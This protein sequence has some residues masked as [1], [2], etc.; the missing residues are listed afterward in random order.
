MTNRIVF[1]LC[2]FLFS[3]QLFGQ[4][5]DLLVDSI[6]AIH[7]EEETNVGL[8]IG[9]INNSKANTYYYGG[10]YTQLI[11]DVD[12]TT[13]FEIGSLT[14]L[15]TALILGKL[16]EKGKINR[17]DLLSQYLP[18]S[19][20]KNSFWQSKIR[21]IDLATH[22]S[23]LPGF[24]STRSLQSFNDFDEN[25]P[26]SLFTKKFMFSVLDT[27]QHLNQYGKINYSNYGIALMALAM[28]TYTNLK[29]EQ[30]FNLYL[31]KELQLKNTYYKVSEKELINLAIPHRKNEV[32]PLIQL[33][34]LGP[35]GSIKSTLPDILTFL[36][37]HLINNGNNKLVQG[38]LANQLANNNE[39][40]GLGWGIFERNG[41]IVNFH[42][43]G[44]YGSSSIVLIVPEKNIGVALLANNQLKGE[45]TS[46]ALKILDHLL[47]Y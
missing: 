39:T 15:Y 40:V 6:S 43:G 33:Y 13:I 44:T 36:Q 4:E 16:E 32:M 1:I 47:K 5:I 29:F 27:I 41:M 9:I 24:E 19:V 2:F 18:T 37:F 12:S 31:R 38:L 22:T 45:L 3:L 28:E 26:Y 35:S 23:G 42:I 11:T 25:D 34:E 21:L 10:K 8:A 17:L 7:F 46:Y 14:K 30:L 20:S